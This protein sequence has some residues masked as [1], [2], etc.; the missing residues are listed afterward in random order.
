MSVKSSNSSVK[1]LIIYFNKVVNTPL[2]V[3]GIRSL[4]VIVIS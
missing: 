3:V 2:L 4:S 1:I